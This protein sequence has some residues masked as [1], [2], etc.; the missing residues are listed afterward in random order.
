MKTYIKY[1]QHTLVREDALKNKKVKGSPTGK[2][3]RPIIRPEQMGQ[4]VQTS[5]VYEYCLGCGR[6]AQAK[7]HASTNIIFWRR[8]FSKP[9]IRLERYRKIKHGIIFDGWWSCKGCRARGPE[10]NKRNC[11]RPIKKQEEDMNDDGEDK[12]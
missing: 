11:I 3:G 10:L 7:Q 9:V 5:G 6:E 12:Q 1:I 4:V 2:K 8:Q